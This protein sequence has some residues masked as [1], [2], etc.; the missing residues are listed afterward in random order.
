[1]YSGGPA[2]SSDPK[3]RCLPGVTH[4]LGFPD[5]DGDGFGVSDH[6]DLHG[7]L[8][9]RRFACGGLPAG[10]VAVGGDL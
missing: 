9:G 7:A 5:T 1:M 6:V 10:W 3:G 8:G 2:F 4:V